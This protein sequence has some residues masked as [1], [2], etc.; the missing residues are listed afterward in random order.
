MELLLVLSFIAYC[1]K[2][3]IFIDLFDIFPNG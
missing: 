3:L 2:Q 1:D